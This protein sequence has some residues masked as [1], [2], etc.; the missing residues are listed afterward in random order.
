MEL[1]HP[2]LRKE[3]IIQPMNFSFPT[4]L[5]SGTM[6]AVAG[7]VIGKL[8]SDAAIF[9]IGR[10]LGRGTLISIFIT[11]FVLPQILLVGDKII[12]KTAFVMNMPVRTRQMSGLIRVDGLVRGRIDG[13]VNGMMHATIRGSMSAYVES[14][15][16]T[17]MSDKNDTRIMPENTAI[18]QKEG[19]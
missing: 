5:S 19:V 14:G 1:R 13:T 18:E 6:L 12:E 10:C 7:T 11:M 17:Q 2:L 8:T 16:M 15:E 9:G 4:I 3:D